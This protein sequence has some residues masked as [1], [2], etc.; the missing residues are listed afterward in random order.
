MAQNSLPTARPA[1]SLAAPGIAALLGAFLLTSAFGPVS[2]AWRMDLHLA[3]GVTLWLF[4]AFVVPA[5][6]TA[7]GGAV[8]GWRWPIAVLLPAVVL[9]VIGVAITAFAP[10]VAFLLAGR[11]VTG[12]GAGAAAGLA[13]MLVLRAGNAR[14]PA[15]AALGLATLLAL[16]LGPLVGMVLVTTLSWRLIFLLATIISVIVLFLCVASEITVLVT[17]RR[18]APHPLG[19]APAGAS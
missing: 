14:T 2:T 10:S 4:V 12:L 17:S 9:M 19:T 15:A 13:M 6:L 3:S 1:W 16:V 18:P 7:A 11:V 5:V 8:L